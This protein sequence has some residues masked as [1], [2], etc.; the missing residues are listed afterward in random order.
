MGTAVG[1]AAT[2]AVIENR[3]ERC[4]RT[5]TLSARV[6]P[7]DG[8]LGGHCMVRVR[9]RAH[10]SSPPLTLTRS[11]RHTHTQGIMRSLSSSAWWVGGLAIVF[12]LATAPPAAAACDGTQV[13]IEDGLWG[14]G[15]AT[16][17]DRTPLADGG[18]NLILNGDFTYS[19]RWVD[20]LAA[21]V[22][23]THKC[24]RNRDPSSPHH[25]PSLVG[26]IMGQR[27]APTRTAPPPRGSSSKAR[28]AMAS[29]PP[30]RQSKTGACMD[31]ASED[32]G[33][34][35]QRQQ[36]CQAECLPI[37]ICDFGRIFDVSLTNTPRT[38]SSLRP[39]PQGNGRRRA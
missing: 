34:D 22:L 30:T 3:A 11:T 32:V 31:G 21:S 27:T 7:C 25:P 5:G 4:R 1:T 19:G 8:G 23:H 37:C 10:P 24:K 35:R 2:A 13:L 6:C 38:T 20:I 17:Q 18:P 36:R 26:R 28:R 16:L 9:S 12:A 29:Q 39:N 14:V 15:G 33:L